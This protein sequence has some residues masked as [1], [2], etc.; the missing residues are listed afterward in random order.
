MKIC[1][2]FPPPA[3]YSTIHKLVQNCTDKILVHKLRKWNP[4][5]PEKNVLYLLEI[6]YK[7]QEKEHEKFNLWDVG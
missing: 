6:L 7:F 4:Y 3:A 1:K 5:I 2:D